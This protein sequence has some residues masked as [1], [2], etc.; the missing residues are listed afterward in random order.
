MRRLGLE[1]SN[2]GGGVSTRTALVLDTMLF[3]TMLSDTILLE[4]ILLGIGLRRVGFGRRIQCACD[5]SVEPG[6]PLG[7][8]GPS[9]SIVPYGGLGRSAVL[10]PA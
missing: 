4:E 10:S 5:Q 1:F 8:S 9:G 6:D 3:D 2:E 7:Q